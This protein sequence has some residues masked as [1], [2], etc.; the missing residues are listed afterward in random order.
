MLN[1]LNVG[2]YKERMLVGRN[3][4]TAKNIGILI[5]D[6]DCEIYEDVGFVKA[7]EWRHRR[8]RHYGGA[9]RP[10]ITEAHGI[11][12]VRGYVEIHRHGT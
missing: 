7:R 10:V 2:P 3:A 12:A 11:C 8:N 1:K 9:C 6:N 5:D 4:S